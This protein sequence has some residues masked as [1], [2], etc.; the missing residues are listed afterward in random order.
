MNKNKLNMCCL[1]KRAIQPFKK[2]SLYVQE[3]VYSPQLQSLLLLQNILPK[4]EKLVV[5]E[6]LLSLPSCESDL[7]TKCYQLLT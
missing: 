7:S 5:L 4:T 6:M 2:S 1:L 3:S